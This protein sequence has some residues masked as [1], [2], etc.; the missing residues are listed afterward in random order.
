MLGSL[1]G[2]ELGT[3]EGAVVGRLVGERDGLVLGSELGASEIDGVE[4]GF[5]L[6]CC[7]ADGLVLGQKLGTLLGVRL[8]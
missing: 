2:L 5:L 4:V 8:G 3:W 1:D 7:D 6:G